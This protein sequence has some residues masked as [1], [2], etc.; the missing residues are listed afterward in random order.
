MLEPQ[1]REKGI[2]L[3]SSVGDDLPPLVSDPHMC[4]HI[5]QN[6][7]ANAVKF[8]A[9]GTVEIAAQRLNDELQVTVRDT[10]I[11]IAAEQ[12][13]HVFDEFW[14]ADGTASRK[15]GGTG[16]GLAIARRYAA[17]LHG[18]ITVE[19]ALG[20]G[21][22]FT[23]TLPLCLSLPDAHAAAPVPLSSSS[24]P[25]RAAAP[26]AGPVVAEG[27]QLLLVEDNEPALIQMVD[28]L[29][30]QGHRVQVARN[31]SEALAALDQSL[32]DAMILDLMM[33]EV[34]GFQVLASVR[35]REESAH[36][37]VLILTAKHV[38]RE[39][40]SFL[41]GNH[42]QQLIQKGDISRAELLAAVERLAAPAPAAK[43]AP[44]PRARG[45]QPRSGR[46]VVLVVEDNPD[47]LRTMR[48]LLQDTYT[49]LE[50][51]DGRTGVEQTRAHQPDLVLMD[52]AMPVMDGLEALR[53]IRADESLRHTPVLAIT[54]SAMK[55][56]QET[57]L[58][59]GFDG[60]LSKPVDVDL[61]KKAL[62]ELLD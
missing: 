2:L 37:P 16:L 46:P 56:D 30:S 23:L 28:V 15:H 10:G 45:R 33:P 5:L 19:S 35:G 18:R 48:A 22:A 7:V 32:P 44:P 26:S 4:R 38:T 41:K 13:A 50:A 9:A 57:I 1:A 49:V 3:S 62:R 52:I 29:T 42:I 20:Q 43:P 21:S 11:G 61:L 31:G 54:A 6:L 27:R 51:T 59:H 8:T 55:G 53:T 34:D 39:E 17:L 24:V 40:L 36:L 25:D 47:S 14:Q 60:Y 12:L 58:A